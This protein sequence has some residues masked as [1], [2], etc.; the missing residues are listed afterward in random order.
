MA[1]KVK[2]TVIIRRK[3]AANKKSKSRAKRKK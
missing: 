3:K 1:T 2:Q